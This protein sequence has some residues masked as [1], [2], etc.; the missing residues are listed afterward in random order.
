VLIANEED[1]TKKALKQLALEQDKTKTA[2]ESER[3]HAAQAEQRFKLAKGSA[4]EMIRIANEAGDDNPA[5][6]FLRRRLLEAALAFYQE[7]INQ[8][9]DDPNAQAELQNTRDHV[10]TILAELELLQK[11]WQ[12]L[13]LG[14]PS[15]KDDLQLS[16]DQRNRVS[17]VVKEIGG[18]PDPGGDFR[19]PRPGAI[20]KSK[21]AV[22]EI[23]A[24]ET[25]I[26]QI[27]SADQLKRLRQ[28]AL[29]VRGSMAFHE[30]EVVSA[31][32]LTSEQKDE[33]RL[34]EGES[35]PGGRGGPRP[36]P[37][38]HP[39]GPPRR[40]RESQRLSVER[41]LALLTDEQTEKWKALI[42]A[43]FKGTVSFFQPPGFGG[44]GDGGPGEGGPG[45][46]GGFGGPGDGRGGP[47]GAGGGGFGGPG[48]PGRDRH[49]GPGG[50]DRDDNEPDA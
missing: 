33:I 29:Q 12:H 47:G 8:R 45:G 40:D 18:P 9:R 14:E 13:L 24:H 5:E 1:H 19:H 28:I 44:P 27:L 37:P 41:I 26:Q 34:I 10:K 11:S 6:Q 16:K 31:L 42:G 35:R 17:E 30:P 48:G 36:G 15:V 39:G 32:E 46:R 2:W 49:G 38:P 23:K 3:E 22:D 20:Q 4:D 21:L 7:F 43:P 50:R 25:A